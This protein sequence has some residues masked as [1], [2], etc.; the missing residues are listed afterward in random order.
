MVGWATLWA[1]FHKFIRS[2]YLKPNLS[3]NSSKPYPFLK[4]YYNM[5]TIKVFLKICLL[6]VLSYWASSDF[7]TM[8]KVSKLLILLP[9]VLLS[10][11]SSLVCWCVGGFPVWSILLINKLISLCHGCQMVCFQTKNLNLGKFWR[12]VERKKLEYSRAVWQI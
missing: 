8:L 11:Q 12:A 3:F 5:N 7:K 2:P 6:R 10:C 4:R 1:I 9:R